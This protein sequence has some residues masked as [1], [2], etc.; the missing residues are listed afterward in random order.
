M[1]LLLDQGLPHTGNVGLGEADDPEILA[2]A[3]RQGR[4][5]VTLDADFH[6]HLAADRSRFPSVIRLRLEGLR[7]EALTSLVLEICDRAADDLSAGAAVTVGE[8]LRCRIRRL[9][10]V[11]YQ[12]PPP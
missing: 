10:F 11:P 12:P 9:P 7:A 3:R 2:W 1:R 8:D 6:R 4:T 5:V